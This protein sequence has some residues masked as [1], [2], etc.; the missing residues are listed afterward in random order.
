MSKV[1]CVCCDKIKARAG[2]RVSVYKKDDQWHMG[3]FPCAFKV[4]GAGFACASCRSK[5]DQIV[6]VR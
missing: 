3:A 6:K 2:D 1:I 5:N 4:A